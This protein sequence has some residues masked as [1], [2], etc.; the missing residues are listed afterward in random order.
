NYR[1]EDAAGNFATCS[2]TVTVIDNIAPT[3]S[4]PTNI[5]ATTNTACTATGVVL[6]TPTTGDNC[7][8]A[9][10]TND[11]P[12][13]FPIGNTTVTWTATDG[14]GNTKTATQLVTVTDNILPIARCK[15]ISIVL[16]NTGNASITVD[17]INDNSSDNCGISSVVASK[18]LFNC[19]NLGNNS[20]T[21]TVT[22]NSGNKAS[23]I[24]TV[25][26]TN[27]AANA[28]IS[29]SAS[30]NTA[31]CV[32]TNITFT[33]SP[34]NAG[35]NPHYQWY[36]NGTPVG[37]D[38]AT[39][40]NT[41]LS[42]GETIYVELRSGP[43]STYVTSNTF[44]AVVNDLPIV[45]APSK[46]CMGSTGT[47]SPTTG[48]T[49]V[50]NNTL[51][52]TVTNGGVITAVAPGTTTFRYT[53]T[54]T[55]CS[56]T[57]IPVTIYALP[58][59]SS[60]TQVCVN[61]TK[62]LSPTTGGTWTSSNTSVATVN[63]AGVISGV[64]VGNAT[65]TF[66]D[67]ISGCSRTTT[68]VSV[69]AIPVIL[70]ASATPSTVCSGEQSTLDAVVQGAT[71][72]ST[73][74]VNYNFNS[75]NNYGALVSNA[76]AGITSSVTSLTIPFDLNNGG[77]VTTGTAFVPNTAGNYLNAD[78]PGKSWI[79][80]LGG[81]DLPNY[82]SFKIYFQAQ[83][84]DTKNTKKVTVSYMKN[85]GT[86]SVI[87][88]SV[89]LNS[90]NRWYV[91]TFTLL[92]GAAN[93][94]NL[95]ITL[96]ISGKGKDNVRIDN[97]QI[98]GIKSGA[99]Y[100][101]S[102]VGSPT[103][104]AGLPTNASVPSVSN[105]TIPVYP[106]VTTEYTVTVA[107]TDGCIETKKV[108]VNVYPDPKLE[109]TADY[110][111]GPNQVRLY[112]NS[113]SPIG[114][115]V[116]STGETGPSITVDTAQYVEVVG[117][118]PE[119]CTYVASLEVA[120]EL[121]TNGSFTEGNTGFT[122]DYNYKPDGPGN[123]E[124]VDDTGK[125][126]YSITTNGQNVH[127]NFWGEDH[128]DNSV[129]NRNFMAVNGHGTTLVVWKET[130]TVQPNT[131][132]YFSA[133]AMSLNSAG[134]NAQLRFQVNGTLV[135]TTAVLANHG[136]SNS[137]TDNWTRFY[138]TWTSG[139]NTTAD[140]NIRDLQSA[141]SGNDFGL[142][143]ISFGTLSPFLTLT[144]AAGTDSQTVCQDNSITDIT[145]SVGSG[146][147]APNVTGLPSGITS[148]FNGITL[149]FTG[150]PTASP[151]TYLY[152]IKTTG[153][154]G[155]LTATG[156]ITIN[157]AAIVNAGTD[158][159]LCST[160]TNVPMAATLGGSATS[161][162]WTGGT[163]SFSNNTPTALYTLGAGDTGTVTLTY[164][165]NDP[166]SAGP[167]LVVSDTVDLIITPNFAANA[168]TVTT[169]LNCA[170]TTVTLAA[171]G[172]IGQWAV[173][174]GQAAGSYSF[175]NTSSPTS[176][177]TGESGETYTLSWTITNLSPCPPSVDTVTFTI[178]N[179]LNIYF[180]GVDD[181][182]DFGNNFNL[183]NTFSFEI[184]AKP[185][186]L[187]GFTKTIL[188]KKDITD[189]STGYDL[190]LENNSI[191]FY[192]NNSKVL[193]HNG[194][195]SDRW[196]HIAVTFDGATYKLYFDGIEMD[197]KNGAVPITNN[198]KFLIGAMNK[199]GNKTI[200]YFNG[201][202][203]ELRIWNISLTN[204]Q[205]RQMMN[206]EIIKNGN[207]V[208][209]A[210]IPLP[211]SGLTW[212]NLAGYYKMNQGTSDVLGGKLNGT[213]FVSGRLLK[214]TQPQEQ[215]APL[216]Y[217]TRA[218]DQDWSTDETWTNYPVWNY[219]NSLGVNGD[220]IDWNIVKLSHN[221]KSGNK[222]ITLLG[223]IIDSDKKL[224]I[225]DPNQGLDEKNN[226][227]GLWITHYLK[228]NGAIDL[229]GE[230]QLVEKRYTLTQS[231]ESILDESS[232]GYIKRDQQGKKSSF[233][234]NYWSSPV[235]KQKRAN[236]AAYSI[237][238]VLRDGTASATPKAI[239]FGDGAYFADGPVT[240][241]IKISKRWLYSYNSPT[242][243]SNTALQNYYLW[244]Y[245]GNSVSLQ[246]GE[247]F[248]MKGT[249]GPASILATQNYTFIGKPNSGTITRY[250]P[251]GQ[252]YLLGNPYPSALDADE[253][254]KDN[255]EGRAGHN[256]INGVLLFWDHF[257]TSN[258]HNL[259]QYEGGYST[260][261][262][263]GGVAGINN[264]P[265][266][267]NNL[268][269]GLKAPERY[270][271]VGQ[272]FFVTASLDPGIK[273][274]TAT[275][276]GGDISFKNSQRTF[277]R[278]A[279][280]SSLFMKQ[281][282]TDKSSIAKKDTRLKIRL[283]FN[284]TA[285]AHRQL[286]LGADANTTNQFDI[287]YDAQMLDTNAN[288]MYWQFS[289]R[290]FIIQAV[291]NFNAD[292]IIPFGINATKA[293]DATIKIDALENIPNDLEIYLYDNVT[294]IYHD[295]RNNVFPISLAVGRYDNR[296]S[297]RFAN[298]T[299]DVNSYD[300]P[301][302]ISVYFTNK[303]KTLN[304][305]NNFIDR[306]VNKIYLFNI[307]AQNISNW[308]VKEREQTSIKIPIKNVPSGVYIVK[309]KTTK[310]DFSKKIIIR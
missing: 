208:D 199:S 296:F 58:I 242:P 139:T 156:T 192:S 219:P 109:I 77:V 76:V 227:Q 70:S 287:G 99:S 246:V 23:C 39:Y 84:E 260:Y 225:A 159:A 230:S 128:T 92:A 151:G 32:G 254:I 22:D 202:L 210:V 232:S 216:P 266:T 1:V 222:D 301:D 80:S 64:A 28:T 48:G 46:I 235:T 183:T 184:W 59:V 160:T 198:Y 170:D 200:N 308:D 25:T 294:G 276:D 231:S 130:V 116:W 74:L 123:T 267:S 279:A 18:L 154:C 284:S 186:A 181:N 173:T 169:T 144:S 185:N 228:L 29:I 258:N 299:L 212:T 285:G 245:I 272:G 201:S 303:D 268:A 220:P 224:T 75:G 234:Y 211:I 135:G 119:G 98:Q 167:C 278:E 73:T 2:Y 176:T 13:A 113:S 141:A 81:T 136:Q 27:P 164:T 252:T 17:Q 4:A 264:S 3:I 259:A 90:D 263:M 221:V 66:T 218:D 146:I 110:C 126:G 239:N 42:N 241:P 55:T 306:T 79:F 233:N 57:T 281:K 226:G 247:G 180:D 289:D 61:E 283:G 307:L 261:T 270:I 31:I 47:L 7:S 255:L 172:A 236:N 188:S 168:G 145:Y 275:V 196:Y 62:V 253:F 54:S 52:A 34:T 21:L 240:V 53:K 251:I 203:D 86:T 8:V 175:S 298:K 15:N 63:N 43:C 78:A 44:T 101:Y 286:L 300:L 108:T 238:E 97:F 292:Q 310:G 309:L 67:G 158:I 10:V 127:N 134:N 65:F 271:A 89:S 104:T 182:I 295:I 45:S 179:C 11:A 35:I 41:T 290:Q 95:E 68:S 85:G 229:V 206:Q 178:A 195:N 153:S 166:D 24:A 14:S 177:F 243:G 40:S 133:Y 205:I 120:Q 209:G 217:T 129:G 114:N 125:N 280:A 87:I 16:D 149:L 60:P 93:P 12:T 9:S 297:I 51:I 124:L 122:S 20:V 121:V 187:N 288:D 100:L 5:S 88:G 214:M 148:S 102:W 147:S 38:S 118:T 36:K 250:I 265:L 137:S 277:E 50:S 69:K 72:T 193:T 30:P 291:P 152:K 293:G 49:W 94:T 163:G 197:S 223:L 194:I 83:R 143:D 262:L 191:S 161:G 248:T 237:A 56:S 111:Y 269:Q 157:P 304:I 19:G 244:N 171:N 257:G 302:S 274:T 305:E 37:T 273:G 107:N 112:A 117:T 82:T 115:L 165:T 105:K 150:I 33:A 71:S 140:V 174:S 138:G 215:T 106:T 142:D 131:T 213:G 96:D 249:G 189:V 103:A 207:N 162:I 6:G 91:G 282:A 132:Y 190:R 155:T 26:I 204:E 256:V